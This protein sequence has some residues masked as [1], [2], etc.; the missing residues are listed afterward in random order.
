[1]LASAA[2]MVAWGLMGRKVMSGGA[3]RK[4]EEEEEEG[5]CRRAV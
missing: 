2:V 4:E 5:G 3:L 1:M